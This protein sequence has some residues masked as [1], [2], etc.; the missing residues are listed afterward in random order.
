MGES[1]IRIFKHYLY[2]IVLYLSLIV[3]V[4][5][6]F[7]WKFIENNTNGDLIIFLYSHTSKISLTFINYFIFSDLYVGFNAI[8][9]NNIFC[10]FFFITIRYC[11]T[12]FKGFF[13]VFKRPLLSISLSFLSL[14]LILFPKPTLMLYRRISDF[15]L[16]CYYV[17]G[18]LWKEIL[19]N[20]I[21]NN[22][23]PVVNSRSNADQRKPPTLLYAD[24]TYFNFNFKKITVRRMKNPWQ[25]CK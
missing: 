13:P 22:A 17:R 14:R 5:K 8:L 21:M 1:H 19:I 11:F 3:E 18:E 24:V 16:F 25:L 9:E 6:Y 2:K 4:W 15:V 12:K 7:F 23:T 20:V 10:F